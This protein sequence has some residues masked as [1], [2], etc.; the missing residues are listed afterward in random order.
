VLLVVAGKEIG[1]HGLLDKLREAKHPDKLS[2]L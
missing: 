2:H 1:G